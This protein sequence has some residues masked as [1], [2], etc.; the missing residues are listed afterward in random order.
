MSKKKHK[1]LHIRA[2]WA[3]KI[4]IK[5][6]DPVFIGIR[7]N[8]VFHNDSEINIKVGCYNDLLGE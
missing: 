1:I 7:M 5:A 4:V 6:Y 2:Y 8:Q 3:E